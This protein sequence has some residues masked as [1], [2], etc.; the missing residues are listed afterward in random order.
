MYDLDFIYPYAGIS[1]L[2]KEIDRNQLFN[3]SFDLDTG[4]IK[5]YIL[6]KSERFVYKVSKQ[7]ISRQYSGADPEFGADPERL[8]AFLNLQFDYRQITIDAVEGDNYYVYME[9]GEIAQYRRFVQSY[10]QR[11]NLS[12]A[13]LLSKVS[14]INNR[15]FNDLEHCCR[16]RAIS[17]LRIPLDASESKIYAQPF[18]YGNGFP[19]NQRTEQFLLKLFSC[20]DTELQAKLRHVWVV[21]EITTDRTLLVTQYHDLL[22]YN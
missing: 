7:G 12:T 3:V 5:L 16:A 17:M 11:F 20:R 22:H 19:L 2:P 13:Q 21:T 8:N 4:E 10:C 14:R 9:R 15:N 18:L 1:L 6:D